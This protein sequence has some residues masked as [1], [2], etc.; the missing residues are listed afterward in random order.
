[1]HW[2][3]YLVVFGVTLVAA[4]TVVGIYSFGV[5]LYAVS[6]D[7]DSATMPTNRLALAKAGAFTCFALSA[8]AV[9]Y[10]IYLIV[11]ALHN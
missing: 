9:L 6:Q 1:M 8:V 7:E 3:D 11:P 5:R 4:L 2:L 10:G